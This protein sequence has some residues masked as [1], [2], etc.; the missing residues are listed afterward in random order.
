MDGVYHMKKNS[1]S[2]Q[3]DMIFHRVDIVNESVES[4]LKLVYTQNDLAWDSQIMKN[5]SGGIHTKVLGDYL[6]KTL[7]KSGTETDIS[8]EV[9]LRPTML[10]ADILLNGLITIES[11]AQGIFSLDSLK[12]RWL[13]LTRGRP[14]LIHVLVSWRHN[15][16]Y[17]RQ[18]RQ[19]M[20]QSKHYYFH[21]LSTHENQP[22]ELERLVNSITNWV[23]EGR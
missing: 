4:S 5:L 14:D 22:Q 12:E 21:D 11:K 17:V 1:W 9:V 19:F 7:N 6:K 15:P 2:E 3:L 20:P 13:K 18:I 16:S 10:R 8:Y 23:R